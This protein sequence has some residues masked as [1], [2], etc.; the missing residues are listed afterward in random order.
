MSAGLSCVRVPQLSTARLC[1]RL[2]ERPSA[3]RPNHEEEAA[4]VPDMIVDSDFQE[5]TISLDDQ[6]IDDQELDSIVACTSYL[7]SYVGSHPR[8]ELVSVVAVTGETIRR[9]Y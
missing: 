5:A 4:I 3:S 9:P 1:L 8:R 2:F 6:D 7:I